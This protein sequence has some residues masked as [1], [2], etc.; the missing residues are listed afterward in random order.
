MSAISLKSIT[1]ITSITTP[2]G[3]DNVFTVHTNDTVERFRIDQSG[4]QSIA[5]IL[6]V[7]QDLDVDGH[8]NLDN[9]SIAGVTTFAAAPVLP[10]LSG[11]NTNSALPVLFRTSSG[12]IDGGSG[13]TYNPGG[14]VLTV[15]GADIS[16]NTFRGSGG[17]GTLTCDNHSST[18][19]VTV[20]NTVDISTVDNAANA[21][22][23]K[24]GSN[25]YIT[26]DTLNTN[27]LITLGNNTTHP[28]IILDGAVGIHTTTPFSPLEIQG[29]AGV[30]DA[31]ITFTRHGSPSNGSIIGHNFY[32]I[33]TDSVA[34]FGAY[35]ESAMDDAY[36]AFHTQ[37]TGGSFAERLRITSVGKV[38]M[39]LVDAGGTGCDPDGNHLL[40][41][42]ASTFQTNKGHIMLTGDSA[43]VG[44][45]PQIVFSESG[46]GSNSAGAYIGHVRQGT[47][48]VGDL[49][50]GT[51]EIAGDVSTVPTERLRI[52]SKGNVRI[53]G[54]ANTT[55][56]GYRL[57]LQGSSNATYLQFF[58]NGTGTTYG[59][60]GSLVGLINQDLY[61]WNREDKDIV[62]GTNN[63][64]AVTITNSRNI[65]MAGQNNSAMIHTDTSDGSDSKRLLLAGGGTS[66]SARGASLVLFGNEYSG[67]EGQCEISAGNSG[68]TNGFMRFYTGGSERLRITSAGLVGINNTE[69]EGKGIDVAHSRTNGYA[70]T[71]DT[72]NLAHIIARNS[73]DAP[74]RFAAISLISGG[75][76]QAEGSINLVQTG[77]YTGD[78]TFKLRTSVSGWQERLRITSGGLIAMGGNENLLDSVLSITNSVGDCIRL[79]SNTT[80]NTFKYGVIKVDSYGNSSNGVQIIGGKS[81]SSYNEVAIGGGVDT[82]YAATQIHFVTAANTTTQ[83]GSVR[84]KIE[85]D[86][87]VTLPDGT[88]G[89]RFGSATSQDFALY[90]SGAN[91][92]IDHFGTGNLYQDFNNDFHMRFYR[93]AGDVRTALTITNG[94]AANPEF[95]IKSNPTSASVNSGTHA[96]LVKFKGAGWNTNSGSTEVGTQLQSEHYYWSGSYSNTF[97]QTYPDF[98]IKMKNSD[99]N[100]YVEKFAFSGDGKMRLISGGGI[101]FHNYGGGSGVSSNTLD[102]YEEGT[103]STTDSS[104]GGLSISGSMSYTKIGRL[105]H[106]LFDITY[107]STSNGAVS[108]ITIPFAYAGNYGSGV[109]G[110]TNKAKPTF[111]HINSNGINFMDNDGGSIHYTNDE[112][113]TKRFIGATTYFTNA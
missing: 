103:H 93:S 25:E 99:S 56:Q 97:G 64:T 35:R 111:I 108:S 83:P 109:C 24:Q 26:V 7:T 61:V 75:G 72:R 40:I 68:S 84:M 48:S 59:S 20:S 90:H 32:R 73:S 22:T 57:T 17:T 18:T 46:G 71:S 86:G 110:W 102:D 43:T 105:V 89:L 94:V 6:T 82:G 50:F 95:T 28:D 29:D 81:D 101:N 51:R 67:S 39:G 77:S 62:F 106:V 104:S 23:V 58:D 113:S 34:G 9:V 96:P 66:N 107:P 52:N 85:S 31:R 70:A 1:G 8:T 42:G 11:T 60:D 80:N 100:S 54:S 15:N 16:A 5:G 33:G 49:V 37:N 27:E 21:F 19:F 63:G 91:S 38:G 2:A 10:S 53:G 76:T 74:G 92:H 65:E 47:N 69:P 55:D 79:R 4:N 30:N 14:D 45:G 87:A 12:A 112:L 98:K 41:R 88:Q 78:L 44:Q 13:L 3:V 36:F